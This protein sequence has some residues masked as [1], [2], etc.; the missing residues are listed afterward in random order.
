LVFAG[1][2]CSDNFGRVGDNVERL[3]FDFLKTISYTQTELSATYLSQW[4]LEEA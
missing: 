3:V 1:G 2:D 4:P